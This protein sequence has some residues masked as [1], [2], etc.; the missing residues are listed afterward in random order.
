MGFYSSLAAVDRSNDV[1]KRSYAAT[2]YLRPNLGR[3]N[4]K[5]LTEALASKIVLEG[6]VAKGVEFTHQGSH[7]KI[8]AEKE[9]IISGGAIQT[10][11]LLE[12]SGIGDP[13][14]LARAGVACK[15]ENRRVGYN[16]QDHVL[17]G[18]MWDLKEG[19]EGF[20]TLHGA[21]FAKVQQEIYEKT[22]GG[23]YSSPGNIVHANLFVSQHD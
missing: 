11:Q 10:P 9:V 6:A 4:L 7:Y 22:K 17:G 8:T 3:P 15:V 23:M 16:F 14:V 5:V 12:L 2:A 18:M 13:Y 20:D 1:G 19:I 21:D